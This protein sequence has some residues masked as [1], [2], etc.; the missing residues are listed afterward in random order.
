MRWRSVDTKCQPCS[1]K[2]IFFVAN[3]YNSDPGFEVG[4]RPEPGAV[5]IHHH[6]RLV[7]D[8]ARVVTP[9]PTV[10]EISL[11]DLV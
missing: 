2:V 1:Q 4:S 11:V 9:L 10:P 6:V 8:R 7:C 5:I 3:G